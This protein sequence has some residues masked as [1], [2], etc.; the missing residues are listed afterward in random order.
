MTL[1]LLAAMGVRIWK[2]IGQQGLIGYV[3]GG[4]LASAFLHWIFLPL[5]GKP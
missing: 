2:D 1:L 3:L 5:L 4:F